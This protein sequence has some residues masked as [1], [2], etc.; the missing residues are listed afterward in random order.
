M[1][2]C[3]TVRDRSSN[4]AV[5]DRFAEQFSNVDNLKA[6]QRNKQQIFPDRVPNHALSCALICC[7][8]TSQDQFHQRLNDGNIEWLGIAK[9]SYYGGDDNHV[10]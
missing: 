9:G 4:A 1:Y 2:L 5:C 7:T 10:L 6:A 3:L 8:K